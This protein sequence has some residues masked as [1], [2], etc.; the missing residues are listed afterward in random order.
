MATETASTTMDFLERIG[1][2]FNAFSEWCARMMTKLLGS[3]N[4]RTIRKMGYIRTRDPNHP[5]TI[6]AGSQLAQVNALEDQMKALSEEELKAVTPKFRERLAKGETLEDLLPEAFAPCPE[7]ARR[8]N[9]M[10]PHDVQILCGS[11]V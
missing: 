8:T 2:G 9:N 11:R 10:P 6:V 4:E 7:A 5:Y 1:D 3:S